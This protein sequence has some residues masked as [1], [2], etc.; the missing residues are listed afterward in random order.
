MCCRD[1]PFKIAVLQKKKCIVAIRVTMK[2]F[3]NMRLNTKIESIFIK[4]NRDGLSLSTHII[5]R[6]I[7]QA[8]KSLCKKLIEMKFIMTESNLLIINS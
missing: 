6:L 3:T 2:C 4:V 5:T 7:H 8:E 1:I